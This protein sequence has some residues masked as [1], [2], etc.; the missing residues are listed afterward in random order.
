VVGKTGI[1][2]SWRRPILVEDDGV[3]CVV[4]SPQA[5]ACGQAPV[6]LVGVPAAP[7]CIDKGPSRDDIVEP[8]SY[9]RGANLG[10]FPGR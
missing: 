8:W 5:T 7:A 10:C 4:V 2:V 1:L 6:M 3:W 9:S